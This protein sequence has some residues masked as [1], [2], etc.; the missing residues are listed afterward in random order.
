MRPVQPAHLRSKRIIWG[1]T[2][3]LALLF[4]IAFAKE[5][6]G[7]ARYLFA[8]LKA[9]IG[10]DV[11]TLGDNIKL[12]TN[13]FFFNCLVGFLGVFLVW[14][15]LISQQA[16]LPVRSLKEIYRTAYHLVL[17]IFRLHG[18]AIFV[19]DGKVELT[20]EDITRKGPGVMVV[21]FNSAVVLEEQ[22]PPMGLSRTTHR[23]SLGML[24]ILG[25]SNT[26]Q[27]PRVCGKGIH[28]LRPNERIRGEVDLRKHFRLQPKIT[29]Y[30]RDGIE[31]FANVWAIFTIGQKPDI[32]DVAYIGPH[33]PENLRVVTTTEVPRMKGIQD[34]QPRR[35][36]ITGIAD[37]LDEADRNEIH[38]FAR[39]FDHLGKWKEYTPAPF[40]GDQEFDAERVFAAV[41]ARARS[42]QDILHWADLPTRVAAGYYREILSQTNYDDLYDIRGTNDHQRTTRFPVPGY[43]AKL[44]VRMRNNGI[45][46]YRLLTPTVDEPL[47]K[48]TRAYLLNELCVSEVQPLTNP[49]I[50]RDRGIKIIFSGFGDL[51]PVSQAVYQQRLDAWA[52]TWQRDTDLTLANGELEALRVRGRAQ[53]EAQ[54]DLW[55]SLSRI[56]ELHEHSDEA[57]AIRVLQALEMA[58]SDPKTRQLLPS[59]TMDLLTRAHGLLAT[60][61]RVQQNPGG[62]QPPSPQLP[63]GGPPRHE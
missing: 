21:D 1:F 29:C 20:K 17:Y 38:H 48:N 15:V 46:T 51:T 19:H 56:F 40:T 18:P 3:F 39:A 27:S 61:P 13:I 63:S 50:L 14:L 25:L 45:L 52:A 10:Y 55:F 28:F 22:D 60:D 4:V 34:N 49:K 47:V 41:F 37:D 24:N 62:G 43:K 53:A 2:G 8:I 5:T 23:V 42:G 59:N 57:L 33:R 12:A 7:T 36:R 30:T 44:R 6:I 11:P 16:I 54:Q 31:L 35:V 32:L 58:A 26:Y 9:L